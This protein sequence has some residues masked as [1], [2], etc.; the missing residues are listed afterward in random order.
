MYNFFFLG[1]W[2]CFFSFCFGNYQRP[3]YTDVQ[4]IKLALSYE[5]VICCIDSVF[6]LCIP[7]TDSTFVMPFIIIIASDKKWHYMGEIK[8]GYPLLRFFFF[9]FFGGGGR[10]VVTR[11]ETPSYLLHQSS[12]VSCPSPAISSSGHGVYTLNNRNKKTNIKACSWAKL[13]LLFYFIVTSM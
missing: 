5:I 3:T 13:W 2:S 4:G 6:G 9:F 1:K 10:G 7:V 11:D 12:R 8:S